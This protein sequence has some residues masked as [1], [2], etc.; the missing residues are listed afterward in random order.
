MKTPTPGPQLPPAMLQKLREIRRQDRRVRLWTGLLR[1]F[2][3]LLAAMLG[4]MTID[5]MVVLYEPGSRWAL[6]LSAL[7][8]AAAGAVLWGLIPVLRS[9]SLASIARQLDLAH[10]ALEERYSTLA[11]TSA[12]TDAPELRGSESMI[13]KVA[14]QA[15]TMSSGLTADTVVEKSGLTHALRYSAAAAGV[16]LILFV[17]DFSRAKILCQRFWAP[18]RDLTLTQ[19]R[20]KSGDVTVG[21]G[22]AVTLEFTSEGKRPVSANLS[23]R[24][25]SGR[26]E[27]VPLK[28]DG[29]ND[30]KFV[31]TRSSV[32]GP[33]EYRA[34]AGDSQTAWHK[35]AV[36]ERPKL[37]QAS[38]HVTPPAY[39]RLPMVEEKTLP[40]EVRA[41]E[42][43]RL[44]V[45]LQA[46][47]P[48]ASMALK[49]SDGNTQTLVASSD[50]SYRF[51]TSLTNTFS[52]TPIFSNEHHLDNHPK[53]PCEIVVYRDEPPSIKVSSPSDE[54]TARP[55][56]KVKIEFEARDDFGL[57]DAKLVVTI[58]GDTNT[59]SVVIP[60]PLKDDA[61]KKLV[62]GQVDLDLAQFNLKQDQELSYVVQVTDTK[63]NLASDNSPSAQ[64]NENQLTQSDAAQ[65]YSTEPQPPK[66]P[67]D[68]TSP[69]NK[70]QSA[71]NNAKSSPQPRE[72]PPLRPDPQNH[73]ALN[74]KPSA[75]RPPSDGSQPPA[76]DMVKRVLDAGQC[77]AC[78]PMRILVDEWGRSFEGQLRAKLE[79]AIDPVLR[80]LDE[81]LGKAQDLTD[82]NLT[83]GK[84]PSGLG[85]K[86]NAP[87]EA[88]RGHLRQADGVVTEL[89]GKT[90]GTPYAFIGLQLHDIRDTHL[91]PARL[92]LGKVSLEPGNTKHDIA[93]L[94]QASFEIKQS[95]EKLAALTRTYAEVKRDYKL[96]DAMQ[97]L[98]KMHQIFLEDTQEMLGSKKPTLNPQNRKVAEVD[99]EFVEKLRKLLEE[100]KKIMAELAKILADDPRML[101]RFLA[102]QELEG[103]SLR[104]QMTLL[105][106]RQQSLA[107]DVARWTGV[108]STNREALL[109]QI[110]TSQAA[111]QREVAELAAKM[112]ENMVAWLPLDAT[113]DS[114]LVVE[115]RKL[116]AEV[117]RLA[118]EASEQ[119]VRDTNGGG[120]EAAHK[121]LDQLRALDSSLPQLESSQWT[122]NP[123]LK[124]FAANRINEVAVLITRQSGWIKKVEAIRAGDYPQAAEVDQYRLT[125]DTR[126]LSEKL[127]ATALQVSPLSPEIG[128]KAE[129]LN[130]TV[131][132]QILP[133]QSGATDALSKRTVREAATHQTAATTAF[134]TAEKQFDE[135]LR[136]I[137]AKLDAE[138]P[139]TK[140]G[141]AETLE[142][143]LAMLQ[144]EKKALEGLG[145][146]CRPMNVSIAK[147]WLKPGSCPN[148]G[149]AA[150]ASVAQARL[151]SQKT[152]RV[153]EQAKKLAQK[154]ASELADMP[155]GQTSGP[156]RPAKSWNTLVSKLGDELRQGRDNIPP[157]QYRHAIEQYFNT[158]S[159]RIPAPADST[160]RI[161]Q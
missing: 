52:F 51:N 154:R 107:Q 38:L 83:A 34:R 32:V 141:T 31:Y 131:D 7:V 144:D 87:L 114:D 69:A 20:A 62:R 57:A 35:V 17:L 39:S 104:D 101:R 126:E 112:H 94:E 115:C 12:S 9:R 16:L 150:Q 8:L 49:F 26:T 3:I 93:N 22:E 27:I 159:A 113:P 102:L 50:R 65:K 18:G 23:V 140:V 48:L 36:A 33:F 40:R 78:Q 132:T 142:E 54:I 146:P 46:D 71:A 25:A 158:I 45:S 37:A 88:S 86:Q 89:K 121:S 119:T 116:G 130:G 109:R 143:L 55:D 145:I 24:S 138:P 1:G 127:D 139:P 61:G 99:D 44:E 41:L 84:S 155:A 66:S 2:A 123:K 160:K 70:V 147:D 96:A 60:I 137:I 103:T 152:E 105:A 91:S 68:A 77:S 15:A 98:K 82:A 6:T 42:G 76:N 81:L 149:A 157:E 90:Q 97:R 125:L 117:A 122:E 29:H 74:A 95:R 79:I 73:L 53:L 58:K 110:L 151:A 85:Q 30:A 21:K 153:G 148:P 5:W 11:E 135:L 133:E 67:K 72:V 43:S 124:L 14:E 19:L 161:D 59:T 80:Q 118:A 120:L 129:E 13:R 111:E 4:A 134:A 47:Q 56:D 92:D 128:S 156:K 100:K 10:P 75:P 108:N 28:R 64:P 106:Q 63:A 136:L